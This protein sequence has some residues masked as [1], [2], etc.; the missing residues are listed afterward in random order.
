M[1][2]SNGLSSNIITYIQTVVNAL[3]LITKEFFFLCNLNS[4]E[5]I[6]EIKS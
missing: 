2:L 1:Y 3:N 5:S 4:I 6:R